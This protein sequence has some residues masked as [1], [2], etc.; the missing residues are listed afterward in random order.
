MLKNNAHV[1]TALA[2]FVLI[3]TTYLVFAMAYPVAY[4]WA[5]YEDL[6]GEWGQTWLYAAACLFSILLAFK[7]T[8]YRWFF[9]VLALACLYVFLEEISWGQRIIGFETPELLKKHN[10]QREA[11]IHNLLVGPISTTTKDVIEYGLASALFLYGVLYPLLLKIKWSVALWFDRKGLASP[12]LYL[13]PLFATAAWLELSPYSFNEAEVAEVL[14]GLSLTVMTVQYWFTQR[15]QLDT[16]DSGS[17]PGGCSLRLAVVI[18]AIV[19]MVAALSVVTTRTL[20]ADPDKRAKIDGR[21]LN[22]YEKFAK[23][24]TS[25]GRLDVAAV[26]LERVH[27]QEPQRASVLRRIAESYKR[28]GDEQQFLHYN[29]L[30]LDIGLKKYAENPDSRST[31]I[32]LSYSYRQRGEAGKARDHARHAHEIALAK[33]RAKPDSA[34]AAYWLAKTYRL[35]GDNVNALAEYKRAYELRPSSS[36]YR[37]A[38]YDMRRVVQ[39]NAQE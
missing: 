25:Y 1:I 35:R 9:A 33:A 18:M 12:P 2:L 11:N 39:N 31:N 23:R 27:R 14:V 13:W 30:A 29:Q 16:N 15:C 28:M 36:K 8:R 10:L 17:W 37:R 6:Y 21:I 5:T 4:I 32:S 7:H 3:V 19:V 38:Y 26:L 22:G 24:Y 20:Y 34:H